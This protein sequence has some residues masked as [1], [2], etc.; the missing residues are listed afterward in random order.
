MS[1]AKR[2][3]EKQMEMDEIE[4]MIDLDVLDPEDDADIIAAMTAQVEGETLTAE[5]TALLDKNMGRLLDALE[6][7]R[8]QEA[9]GDALDKDD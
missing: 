3:L 8:S 2:E 1:H 4:E 6:E 5:Q 9:L 7:A